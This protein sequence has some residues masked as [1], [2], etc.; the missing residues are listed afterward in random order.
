MSLQGYNEY[1]ERSH[2]DNAIT[3]GR[4]IGTAEST[5]TLPEYST[6]L[7]VQ[8]IAEH[9]RSNLWRMM[10]RIRSAEHLYKPSLRHVTICSTGFSSWR[11]RSRQF[12]SWRLYVLSLFVVTKC[13]SYSKIVLSLIVAT[14]CELLI[15]QWPIRTP[16]LVT[17]THGSIITAFD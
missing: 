8:R 17:N 12:K 3:V 7:P 4:C 13:Y 10:S 2:S 1:M 9:A 6:T 5:N 11:R 14:N 16:T 15:N